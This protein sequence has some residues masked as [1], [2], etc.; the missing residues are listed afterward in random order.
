MPLGQRSQLN[1]TAVRWQPE[2]VPDENWLPLV[3][4]D[5]AIDVP[6]R[7]YAPD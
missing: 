6:M 3:P 4:G 1:T 2:D 7:I 5:Y